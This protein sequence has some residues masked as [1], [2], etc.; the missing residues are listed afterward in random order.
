MRLCYVA[1]PYT[2]V[3]PWDVEQHVR[4]AEE[5]GL[6]IAHRGVMPVIPHT[7]CRFFHNQCSASFWYEGTMKLL[8]A[9]HLTQGGIFMLNGW[10]DSIGAMEEHSF[11]TSVNMPVFFENDLAELELWGRNGS[12]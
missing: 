6:E 5:V 9:V 2:G 11:A 4:R 1:G 8:E 7:N 12:V 3:T 10:Q